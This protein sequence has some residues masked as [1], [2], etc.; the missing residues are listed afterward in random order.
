M[1][2]S[3]L[4]WFPTISLNR[5]SNTLSIATDKSE[6]ETCYCITLSVLE[7]LSG[8]NFDTNSISDSVEP[9][10][11]QERIACMTFDLTPA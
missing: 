7:P 2:S 3:F 1:N 9:H 4:S 8:K 10:T 6:K 5:K 11:D